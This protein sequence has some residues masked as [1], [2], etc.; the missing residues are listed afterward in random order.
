MF[1]FDKRLVLILFALF[2]TAVPAGPS[3]AAADPAAVTAVAQY[4]GPDRDQRLLEGAKK[5]GTLTLYTSIAAKDV[6]SITSGFEK[7]YGI[8]VNVWRASVNDVLQRI[9]SETTANRFDFDVVSMSTPEMEALN[10]EKLLQ[11]VRDPHFKDM[12]PA[13]LPASRTWAGVYIN[14]YAQ[15][16]NLNKV[17]KEELPKTYRDLLDPKWK[18]R[19]GIEVKSQEWFYALVKDMGEE[20]GLKF[21]RDLVAINSPSGRS[22]HSVLNNMVVAGDVPFAI[23]VYHYLPMQSK[24]EGAPVDWLTLEPTIASS[25]G[26]GLSKRASRPNAALLFYDYLITDAQK[27]FISQLRVPTNRKYDSPF[28]NLKMRL[29]DPVAVLN[30][31]EKASKLFE[32]VLLKK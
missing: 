27:L 12:N 24:Q 6:K 22:G 3:Q 28:K 30:E 29:L 21:F 31:Y 14:C 4:E 11:E 5:E 15:A 32:D 23:N 1:T 10:R 20:K 9:M 16:Y 18:G 25:F 26:V 2:L 8:K 13:A 17:K 19:L 7:K